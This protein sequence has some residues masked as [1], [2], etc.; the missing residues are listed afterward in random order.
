MGYLWL[1]CWFSVIMLSGCVGCSM[2]FLLICCRLSVHI[3]WVF[4]IYF[5][6]DL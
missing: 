6:C 5:V 4:C 1:L 2:D 3:L